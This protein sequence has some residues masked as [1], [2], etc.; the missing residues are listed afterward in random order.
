[1]NAMMWFQMYQAAVGA[2]GAELAA[3]ASEQQYKTDVAQIELETTQRER[4]RKERLNRALATSIARS[5]AG[6]VAMEGSPLANLK[7]MEKQSQVEGQRLALESRLAKM[8]A[9]TRSK[10][11]ATALRGQGA[12]GLAEGVVKLGGSKSA[13]EWADS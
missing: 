12:M 10:M 8:T 4:D 13:Q 11:T 2:Y 6:G 5:A 7:E 9:K 3:E 1:M